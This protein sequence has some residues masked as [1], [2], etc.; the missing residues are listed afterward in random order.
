MIKKHM[1]EAPIL[2]AYEQGFPCPLCRVQRDCE[3]Q[4]VESALGSSVMEPSVRVEVNEKGFCEAHLK[5]LYDSGDRLPLALMLDTHLNEVISRVRRERNAK[6]FIRKPAELFH[7]CAI[8]D[9]LESTMSRY[10]STL[11]YI[12]QHD[13]SFKKTFLASK[14]FCVRHLERLL[15][16]A[17]ADFARDAIDLTLANLEEIKADVN[18]YTL[19]FDYRNASKPWGTSLDA[20]YRA[21]GALRGNHNINKPKD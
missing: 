17:P 4:Y 12:Y 14:G 21:I 7:S 9:K 18:W 19:K 15:A 16:I 2:E 5:M 1:D 3:A 11:I 6:R 20:V 10:E 8:C 13:A